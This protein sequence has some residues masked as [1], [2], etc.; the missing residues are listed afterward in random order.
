M[1]VQFIKID[2]NRHS[3]QQDTSSKSLQFF[4]IAKYMENIHFYNKTLYQSAV[5]FE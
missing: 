1:Y 3:T 4:L 5:L 2:S